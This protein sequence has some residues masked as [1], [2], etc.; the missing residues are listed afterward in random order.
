MAEPIT[1]QLSEPV[2]AHGETI[3]SIT[4]RPPRGKDLIECGVPADAEG[5]P[6]ER[7]AAALISRLAAVP[8]STLEAMAARDFMAVM[9]ALVPFFQEPEAAPSSSSDTST[10]PG[11]GIAAPG[12]PS[13]SPQTS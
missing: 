1:I 5:R 6:D 8:P 9:T 3:T 7:R 11:T 12:T 10:L 13:I 2:Q 4:L